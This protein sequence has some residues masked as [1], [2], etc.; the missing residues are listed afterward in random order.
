MRAKRVKNFNLGWGGPLSTRGGG[1]LV[2]GGGEIFMGAVPVWGASPLPLNSGKPCPPLK[3]SPQPT[4]PPFV[5]PPRT[6]LID[7]FVM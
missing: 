5:P 6:E 3:N 4:P 7:R 1:I 2:M